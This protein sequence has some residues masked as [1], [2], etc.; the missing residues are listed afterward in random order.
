MFRRILFPVDGSTFAEHAL[1]YVADIARRESASVYVSLVHTTHTATALEPDMADRLRD[2]DRSQRERDAEYLKELGSRL[3][4]ETG[5][6][7]EPRLLDG[8]VVPM[9][10]REVRALDID[11]VVMTSHGRGGME[12]AWLGSVADALVR[13]LDVPVLLVRPSDDEPL[14]RDEAGGYGHVVI[15]LDGSERADRAIEP[16]LALAG[17]GVRITLLR[18]VSPPPSVGSPY[19]PHAIQY[20]HDEVEKRTREAQVYLTERAASLR[21][22]HPALDVEVAV[23]TDMHTARAILAFAEDGGAGLIAITTHGRSPA[24]RLLMGSVT[25]KVVRAATV[26]VL[27]C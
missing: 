21:Q 5:G 26:P 7:V 14:G 16:A 22:D 27:V 17:S 13:H 24:S 3:Q 11:L 2:W 6:E 9:L 19:L 20:S 18:V 15:A 8:E 1:P 12:R 25:D 4:R 23:V 10:E